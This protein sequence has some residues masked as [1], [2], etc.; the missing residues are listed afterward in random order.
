[1]KISIKTARAIELLMANK[2]KHSEEYTKQLV[3]WKT[4]MEEYG[5][6]LGDWANAEGK[7]DEREKEPHRPDNYVKEYDKML[8]M[9]SW[10]IGE[11]IM[12][13]EEDFD[14]IVLDKFV[15]SGYFLANSNTYS[16]V[17]E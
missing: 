9:L 8:E 12:L 5:K 13:N 1:M 6:H 16:T 14:K 10:H 7:R 2:E 17:Q 11:L 4:Q 3:G 15:W